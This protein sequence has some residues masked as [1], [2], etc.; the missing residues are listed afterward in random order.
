MR[1]IVWRILKI[2]CETNRYEIQV[3]K[4]DYK[5]FA[6]DSSGSEWKISEINDI[7]LRQ[8]GLMINDIVRNVGGTD[9]GENPAECMQKIESKQDNLEITMEVISTH[10]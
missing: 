7:K 3:D 10:S 4:R 6:I 2:L 5:E 8:K 1:I 9:V